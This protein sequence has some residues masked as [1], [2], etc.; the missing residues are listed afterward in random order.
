MN[1][2]FTWGDFLTVLFATITGFFIAGLIFGDRT[3]VCK[4]G[5]VVA[6]LATIGITILCIVKEIKKK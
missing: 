1:E 4:I 2:P 3:P 6:A 5:V